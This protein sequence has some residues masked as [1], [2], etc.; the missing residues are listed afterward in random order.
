M[1]RFAFVSLLAAPRARC[2]QA[3]AIAVLVEVIRSFSGAW[4]GL[5]GLF[6]RAWLGQSDILNGEKAKL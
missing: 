1:Y 3:G 2:Q 6:S 5:L 4:R